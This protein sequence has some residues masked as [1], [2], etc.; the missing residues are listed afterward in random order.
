MKQ[1]WISPI[2]C[3]VLGAGALAQGGSR[4]G[5]GGGGFGGGAQGGQGQEIYDR[6]I[7]AIDAAI[8]TYLNGDPVS[9]ILTPGEYSEWTLR[10]KP[11]QV[12]IAEAFSEAF[13]PM[14][15]IV[16]EGE[17]QI[18][19]N[20]DRYPGDQRPLLLWR[21][22]REGTYFLRVRSFRGRAGG[23]FFINQ[24]VYD[25]MDISSDKMTDR[26]FESPT[27]FLFRVQMKAGE[28][29]QIVMPV[30]E[31][32]KFFQASVGQ[33]ISPI[34][35]PDI[36]LAF[37]LRPIVPNAILAPVDGTYYVLATAQPGERKTLR[38]GT[39]DYVPAT[40][41]RQGATVQASANT[42]RPMLW[43]MKVKAG[44]LLQ[45]A[46]P[47]LHLESDIVVVEEPDLS[48]FDLKNAES[49][50]FFPKPKD[51]SDADIGPAFIELPARERDGRLFVLAAKRDATLWIASDGV[52]EKDKRYTLS[53]AP[54]ARDY[55][56]GNSNHGRLTVGRTDYWTFD[57]KVGDVMTFRTTA[58]G[59]SQQVYL[60][61]PDLK[62]VGR[63]IALPDQAE[64]ELDLIVRKPGRYL[65]WVSCYGD[66]GGGEYT[67]A[68]SVFEPKRFGKNAAAIGELADGDVQVWTFT[69]Q[70][71]DPLLIRWNSTNW[72]YSINI[73]DERGEPV[74]L[75]L[76]AVDE[77]NRYGI[78]KVDRPTTFLIVLRAGPDKAKYSI[79]LKELPGMK[80]G[81]S[82]SEP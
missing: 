68:R 72:S 4:G 59:F 33:A 20:D 36:G 69:A 30:T 58:N 38:A 1:L 66:G 3:M 24:M 15:E 44:E 43:R 35:L 74:S 62:P 45:I 6:S 13:D 26:E 73:R 11:G 16:A 61:D 39:V 60:M 17:T 53:V 27:R 76:T 21:C 12:V 23:Q 42:N 79:E 37:P 31:D 49:N 55:A 57:A 28:I 78:L 77:S 19:E 34:G 41:E 54:A 18:F 22:E 63:E 67:L 40:L 8:A 47:D 46:T 82:G 64:I 51:T 32:K 14:L 81:S 80:R 29:K 2:L 50:P 56:V 65:A 48:K 25:S 52:G 5:F 71:D 10:L 70:P 75:P 7:R 9:N